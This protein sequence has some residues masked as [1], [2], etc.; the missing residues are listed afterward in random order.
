MLYDPSK[1]V[2]SRAGLIH[3]LRTED[4]DTEYDYINSWGCVL[5]RYLQAK[6]IQHYAL[7]TPE[8]EDKFGKEVLKAISYLPTEKVL[9]NG[10]GWAPP[11]NYGEALRRL[12]AIQCQMI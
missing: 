10:R 8:I 4:P 1:D 2:F 12:E 6:G 3:W 11:R 9:Y 5:A 7:T